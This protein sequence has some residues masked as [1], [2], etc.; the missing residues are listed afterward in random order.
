MSRTLMGSPARG[1]ATRRRQERA[2]DLWKRHGGAGRHSARRHGGDVRRLRPLRHSRGADRCRPGV[3]RQGPHGHLQQCR[4]RRDRPR[5]TARDQADPQ[6]GLVLCRREQAV[7]A[8]IS[9]RRAGAG[10][11][12]AGH[13]GRAHPRRR[14]RHS[15]LLHQDWRR[16]DHRRRQGGARVR[17]RDVRDGAR[18]RRR[19][20][21]RS[22]LQG[23]GT[24]TPHRRPQGR[25][26]DGL[27][28]R[29]D[30]G[31]RGEGIAGR[32]L[33]QSRHRHPDARRQLHSAR[34]RRLPAER[35]RHAGHGP[36]PV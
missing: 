24:R 35:E 22:C 29:R 27:D 33:R 5:A 15:R 34:D 36:L 11:Q 20:R 14:R 18:A 2:K 12:S 32:V 19:R 8:A 7:R 6:D 26:S 28:T 16:H 1:A 13:A 4:R 3:R 30:G 23:A 17:R 9:F 31:P 21:A 10:V 25:K